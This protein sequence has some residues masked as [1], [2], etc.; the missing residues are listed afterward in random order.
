M[1]NTFLIFLV[2]IGLSFILIGTSILFL[3]EVKEK[4][5]NKYEHQ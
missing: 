1:E 3:P 2:V 4:G 5:K